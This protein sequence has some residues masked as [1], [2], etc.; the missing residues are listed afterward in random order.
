MDQFL[1]EPVT[2]VPGTFDPTAMSHGQP[3]LPS[4][5]HC[6]GAEHTVAHVLRTWK[7]SNK[8]LCGDT[9]LRR[10]WYEVQTT[11]GLR[12]TLYCERQKRNL[13]KPKQRWWV[14]TIAAPSTVDVTRASRQC[15]VREDLPVAPPP[16]NPSTSRPQGTDTRSTAT[17]G[18]MARIDNTCLPAATAPIPTCA[19][20]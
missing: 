11:T 10:H 6:H 12:I 1:S 5:F 16:P 4:R 18:S 7:S 8:G 13:K 15:K 14:Y 3:G 9:Y 17:P 20:T 2:P 19:L